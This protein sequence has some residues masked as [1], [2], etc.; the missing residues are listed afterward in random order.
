MQV[1]TDP[2]TL[3]QNRARFRPV[4][5]LGQVLSQLM[6]DRTL[7]RLIG[8]AVLFIVGHMIDHVIR[9]GL[10]RSLTVPTAL[11]ILLNLVHMQERCSG[12]W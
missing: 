5:V 6:P 12:K 9:D 10:G 8:L 7:T 1:S 2:E 11:F 3:P 4:N